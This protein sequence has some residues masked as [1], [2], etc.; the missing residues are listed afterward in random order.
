[1]AEEVKLNMKNLGIYSYILGTLFIRL[2]YD[3]LS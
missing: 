2:E 3:Q 1:M